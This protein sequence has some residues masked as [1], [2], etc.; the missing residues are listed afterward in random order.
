MF[1][2]L[3]QLLKFYMPLSIVERVFSQNVMEL[4]IVVYCR[5][6]PRITRKK[7]MLLWDGPYTSEPTFHAMCTIVFDEDIRQN[8]IYTSVPL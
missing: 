7:A 8:D 1:A 4:L 2:I 6:R 5:K 3:L